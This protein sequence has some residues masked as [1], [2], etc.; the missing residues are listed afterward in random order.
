MLWE[1]FC[2]PFAE[3][4]FMWQALLGMSCLALGAA[5]RRVRQRLG[6]G[7][8]FRAGSDGAGGAD[9]GGRNRGG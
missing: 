2:Q 5:C 8:R 3:F 9:R 1:L 6:P 7:R 4:D